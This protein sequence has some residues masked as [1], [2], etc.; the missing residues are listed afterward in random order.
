MCDH[1]PTMLLAY[2]ATA[3]SALQPNTCTPGLSNDAKPDAWKGFLM[4]C[5]LREQCGPAPGRLRLF[6]ISQCRLFNDGPTMLLAYFA[7]A[8]LLLRRWVPAIVAFSAAVSVKMNVLL[9]APSVL[10]IILKVR[11][12]AGFWL[13]LGTAA[14][15]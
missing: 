4:C 14:N 5:R 8:L 3:L 1:E 9:M 7:T 12:W 6:T 2:I 13:V 15:L 11:A 10:L